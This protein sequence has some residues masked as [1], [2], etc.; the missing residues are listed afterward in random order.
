[1]ASQIEAIIEKKENSLTNKKIQIITLN[2]MEIAITKIFIKRNIINKQD[3]KDGNKN[4]EIV[5]GIVNLVIHRLCLGIRMRM[6]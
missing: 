1:M 2:N 4:R 3:M 6:A 5:K